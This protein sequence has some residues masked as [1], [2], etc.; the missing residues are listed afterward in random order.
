MTYYSSFRRL[1]IRILCAGVLFLNTTYVMAATS[2]F[3][4]VSDVKS[5]MEGTAKTVMEGTAI[6]D[7]HVKVLGV[8]KD[9]GPSGDLILAEFSGAPIERAGGIAHGMS[10]SPVY[11]DGKLVGAVAYGW[12]FSRS[13]IGMIT[14]I[15]QMVKL[16]NIP[17]TKNA[18]NPWA[19]EAS[20]GELFP[21][22]TPFMASGFDANALAFMK[23][24][25]QNYSIEAYDTAAGPGDDVARPLQA[26]GSIAATVVDG[27]LKLGAIGTVTYA[28]K[29]KIVAFG[30]PFLQ[31]G[32]TGYFMHNAYIFTVVNNINS[33]FKLGSIGA[34]VGA[35]TEDRG[36]G[37]A[38]E[39]GLTPKFI[40]VTIDIWDADMGEGQKANVNIIDDETL[41]PALATTAVYNYVTKTIDRKGGGTATLSYIITPRNP[42][43]K[44][45]SRTNMFYSSGSISSKSMDEFYNILERLADNTFTDYDIDHIAVNVDVTE[46]RKTARIESATAAPVVVAPGDVINIR[47]KLQPYREPVTY[48]DL[49]FTVPKDQAMGNMVLEVRGGGVTPL[50]YLIEK[51]RYNLTDEIIRRL[52]NYKN[53]DD[54]FKKI[55]NIDSNNQI[56]AELLDSGLSMVDDD[57]S[58]AGTNK[59]RLSDIGREP[60]PNENNPAL[61]KGIKNKPPLDDE[62]KDISRIDTEYVISGDGQ[63]NIRVM[64][65]SERDKE[66]KKMLRS[67]KADQAV[68][69]TSEEKIPDVATK[70]AS[71]QNVDSSLEKSPNMDKSGSKKE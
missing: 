34:T 54:F 43:Y 37:I 20:R 30:H 4:P 69:E 59:A 39:E 35:V 42:K 28:D 13:N 65:V 52:R 46:A 68:T 60:L 16:W 25:L 32:N 29:G 63:F 57:S 7:F 66:L 3:M 17:Y 1:S 58:E 44:P 33:S 27:D 64:S 40:P 12:G 61:Q 8:M 41:S 15:E 9:R 2:D 56:V 38:G 14:P 51:Q 49:T 36:A 31:R 6:S 10:G 11:I 24:K 45:F 55:Q 62:D 19:K 22:G 71:D 53:F 48:R 50:P 5:G 70:K 21:L 67:K 23:E 26:G 47:V 18:P